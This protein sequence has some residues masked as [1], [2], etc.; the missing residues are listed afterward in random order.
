ML[1]RSLNMKTKNVPMRRCAG[2]MRSKP[3]DQLVRIACYQ[4]QVSF[5]PTGKA[6]GRGV[7]LCPS[8]DCMKKAKKKRSLQRNFDV[9]VSEERLDQIFDEIRAYAQEHPVDAE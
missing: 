2:C 3:K 6:K 7:Y 5:D 1:R 9:Q 4:G 8:E